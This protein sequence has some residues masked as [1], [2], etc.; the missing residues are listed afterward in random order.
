VHW[1]PLTHAQRSRFT[2]LFSELLELSYGGLLNR[3]P[4]GTRFTID[5]QRIEGEYAQVYTRM[6]N[7]QQTLS[8]SINYRLRR[9]NG[10]WLI[11]DMIIENIS[12]VRNYRHQLNRIILRSGYEGMTQVL[13]QKLEFLRRAP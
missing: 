12:L 5:E 10:T 7:P 8:F 6:F 9:V 13:E 2:D 4:E 11:Y 3:Y 1:A